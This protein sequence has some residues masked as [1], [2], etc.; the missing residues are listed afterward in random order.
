M[1][2]YILKPILALFMLSVS[3][4]SCTKNEE[5]ATPISTT[6]IFL[7]SEG[8]GATETVTTPYAVATSK[9]IFATTSGRTIIE[10]NL[11]N[12]SVG[13]YTLDATNHFTYYK[14]GTSIIWTGYIGTIN[15]TAN[16][17]NKISGNFHINSGNG[18]PTIN[19]VSGTFT[20][21]IIN[22]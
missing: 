5:E 6:P 2:K 20:N 19:E 3:L 21:I 16:A 11:S 18:S 10:I 22:P 17:S 12:L 1:K 4:I 13:A 14:P 9:S 8:G 7:Y 15:I